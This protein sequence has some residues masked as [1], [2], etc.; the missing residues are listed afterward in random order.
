MCDKV[1]GIYLGSSNSAAC[2]YIDGKATM[3]PSAE[4]ASLYGKSFPSYVA[5]LEDGE[6]LVG[7]PAKNYA[8]ANPENV[9]SGIIRHMGTD[10]KVNIRGK[11]YSSQEISA[12]ILQKIK[13]DAESFLGEEITKA[14]ITVPAYFDD[15]QRIATRDAGIIAGFEVLGI[16]S[17]PIAASLAYG[18][19]KQEK[20]FNILVFE[21]GAGY[22][23]VTILNYSCGEFKIISTGGNTAL[24]GTDMDYVLIKYLADEFEKKYDVDLTHD[25]H[26][27]RRLRECAERTKITLSNL[28]ETDAKLPF[29]AMG[30]DGSPLT[31]DETINRSKLESL[32]RP[33]V[34]RCGESIDQAIQDAHLTMDD[35]DK[36]ILVGGSTKMPIVQ[37]YVENYTGKQVEKGIDRGECISQ[38]AALQS[39]I[40]NGQDLNK[41]ICEFCNNEYLR[42]LKYCTTCGSKNIEFKYSNQ[43]NE[44]KQEI[45][46]SNYYKLNSKNEIEF[47]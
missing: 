40:L 41:K 38:G 46:K 17:E 27:M 3:I 1:L 10:Y 34:E 42:D 29:I 12:M 37:E 19:D 23:D 31:L 2:V 22:L 32:V 28:I 16:I 9:I 8:K 44:I 24:G 47:L 43:L 35:I 36:V 18:I 13:K 26:S 15:N 5:F 7:E 6:T 45:R 4:G 11:D 14:V 33:I 20:D 25:E 21:L 30:N 39:A